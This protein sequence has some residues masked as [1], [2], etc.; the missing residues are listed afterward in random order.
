MPFSVSS[1]NAP[2]PIRRL[3]DAEALALTPELA[4]LAGTHGLQLTAAVLEPPPTPMLGCWTR[5]QLCGA[6]F[7]GD[8]QARADEALPFL[9]DSFCVVLLNHVLEHAGSAPELLDEATRV[10]VPGGLLALTGFHPLSAWTPW[11]LCQGVCRPALAGPAW[12][13]RRL[14]VHGVQ[15]YAVRRFGPAF[16]GVGA[17]PGQ[18]LLGG[19]FL[20]LARKRRAAVTPL[21]PRP[22]PARV[23]V[24]TLA[25]GA[26]RE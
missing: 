19:G 6:R 16:P 22:Q 2:P 10:L 23:P 21:R 8:L 12:L 14:A 1:M 26:R 17:V 9:D 5:L 11:L 18:A 3:L 13:R 4:G 7:A 15:T 24:R 20:L 25:P